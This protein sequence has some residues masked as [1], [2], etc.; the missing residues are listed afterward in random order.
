MLRLKALLIALALS[1]A[2][3]VSA[4]TRG[5]SQYTHQRWT[6]GSEAPAPVRA[7]TQD[8]D[9]FLWLATDEGLFRFDGAS[10][11]L[12]EPENTTERHGPPTALLVTRNGDVW[13][14]YES[15]GQ[16]A[17]YRAGALRLI[18]TP[19]ARNRITALAEG[20][21]G[22][23]WGL[24]ARY[25]AEIL[26]FKNGSWR[27]FDASDGLPLDDG[28]S[29]LVAR[30]GAVWASYSNSVVRLASGAERFE[31]VRSTP[32]GNGRLSQDR[33]GRIWLSEANGSYPLTG[34]AGRGAPP[35]LRSPY[36]IKDSQFRNV[37]L[38]DRNGNLWFARRNSGVGRLAPGDLMATGPQRHP[39][40]SFLAR[41]GLSS[42]VTYAVFEDREGNIWFGTERGLDKFRA[43]TLRSDT[44]LTSPA[45][46]GDKLLVGSDGSVYIGQANTI[47]RVRPG[48]DPTAIL[49]NVREPQCM[50]EAPDGAI[51]IAFS[52]RIIAWRQGRVSQLID[53]P[54]IESSHATI[55][56]CAFDRRGDFWFAAGGGGLHRYRRG[57]WE[58]IVQDVSNAD[59][60]YPM[61]LI[62]D[63][64]GRIV[65]QWGRSH[66]ALIDEPSR[67]VVA[68]PFA[69]TAPR[70]AQRDQGEGGPIPLTLYSARN[71]DLFVAGAFG[72]SRFRNGDA[73]TILAE[74]SR[75]AR[76]SGMTETLQGDFWIA[77]PRTIQRVTARE[78][79][80]AF[81]NGT[82]LTPDVT[83]GFGDGLISRPHSHTQRAI[84]RGGDGRLWIATQTGTVS[85]DPARIVRN[86]L[87]AGVAIRY[88]VADRRLYRDPKEVR[89]RPAT[90][91]IEI[92]FAAL[93]FA[94]PHQVAVRYRLEG[95][96][97]EWLDPGG[98]RQAFYTSLPPGRYRFRVI[99]ANNDGVWNQAGAMT[100]FVIPPT[101][102]QSGWFWVLCV[103]AGLCALWL[104]YR[105]RVAQ[106]AERIRNRLEERSAER[107]RIA[108]E[109]HDTLL[110]GV[111]GLILRFQAVTERI[112][113]VQTARGEL[114]AA[115]LAADAVIIDARDRV[116]DLR[117]K[118]GAG[119]IAALVEGLV[120][121]TPFG[122]ETTVRVVVEGR[123]RP[124]NPLVAAEIA[125]I[126]CE[127]LMNIAH[128][129]RAR[130][131]EVA[132]SFDAR[133]L[134][135]RIRDDGV[136]IPEEVLLRGA[137]KGHFGMIGMRERAERIGAVFTAM[138][139]A[140]GGTEVGLSLPIKLALVED[141][142][143]KRYWLSRLLT[144][145]K[146]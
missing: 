67:S 92:D 144:R 129:A 38:F 69:R 123:P 83:L 39:E 37:P 145:L 53:R 44:L 28:M 47:Y 16:F 11:E 57:R 13:T 97:R 61:T 98:R 132:I 143:P 91:N 5:L 141:R 19:R 90:A 94:D 115:L 54:S 71:G 78:L 1:P 74:P 55:H 131:A 140:A 20:L 100:T 130:S 62:A 60:F 73:R 24:T 122:A 104:M 21:D 76:I 116:Q 40:E 65:L 81:A 117:G 68:L 146:L 133:Q 102:V 138:S 2:F 139:G 14:N 114:E 108:R 86:E 105:F 106:I 22:A 95:F 27:T 77:Y 88:L 35:R 93:S 127:A 12:I 125:R 36:P 32:A 18:E 128:H 46:F 124:L 110:Q 29:M 66:I 111:Q 113:S 17:V 87:P 121:A 10:F 85:M 49:R 23:V 25:D 84:V 50:A 52:S 80:R 118:E 101:F 4:D 41:D 72:L 3:G 59:D 64:R 96:D 33:D 58:A 31:R 126:V 136:G 63:A 142:S 51:W 56:D 43:A 134:L 120:A 15:S 99:A 6:Q 7:I 135:V 107:D 48:E 34:A 82:P 45:V 137:R 42:D 89:L 70:K 112:P 9:G 30:D 119:D 79:E 8:R 75:N 26:R 109:L 103:A